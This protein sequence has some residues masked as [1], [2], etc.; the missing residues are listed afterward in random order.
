MP[1]I[2]IDRLVASAA[3]VCSS[4]CAFS[5]YNDINNTRKQC[6][7]EK[8]EIQ[9]LLELERQNSLENRKKMYS[10]YT[11]PKKFSII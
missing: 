4:V 9:R 6:C 1:L 3:L 2:T 10:Y 7:K 11:K 8:K 5:V